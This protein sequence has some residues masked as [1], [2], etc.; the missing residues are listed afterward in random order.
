MNG[1]CPHC[2]APATA[3]QARLVAQELRKQPA[4][5]P[6][7]TAAALPK[8]RRRKKEGKEYKRLQKQRN[9]LSKPHAVLRYGALSQTITKAK[10]GKEEE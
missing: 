4:A 10:K 8:A 3:A 2:R 6:V 9:L 5:E 7:E 1:H